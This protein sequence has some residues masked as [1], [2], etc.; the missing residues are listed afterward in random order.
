MDVLWVLRTG[1]QV[2]PV[3]INRDGRSQ[4]PASVSR[5]QPGQLRVRRARAGVC[6]TQPGA[7]SLHPGPS[8]PAQCYLQTLPEGKGETLDLAQSRQLSV[9]GR[10]HWSRE[11]CTDSGPL[12]ERKSG[13]SPLN[14]G[15]Q[16]GKGSGGRP[17]LKTRSSSR[18]IITQ[19]VPSHRA[20][21]WGSSADR[22]PTLTVLV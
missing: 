11:K 21:I 1:E 5:L 19:T 14:C 18:Q 9:L 20:V 6:N 3:P 15:S 4:C 7:T 12:K 13:T 10:G 2:Q 16:M 8:P 22:S 17:G